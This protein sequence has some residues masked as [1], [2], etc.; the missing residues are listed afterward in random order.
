MLPRVLVHT[1]VSADGRTKGFDVD[2]GQFYGVAADWGADCMLTG[3]DTI[4]LAPEYVP[5][6]PS[7]PAP[8]V[9]PSNAHLLAVIDAR[10]RVRNWRTLKGYTQFWRD[11]LAIVSRETP[12]EYVD[13]VRRAGCDALVAGDERVDLRAAL[14]LLAAEHGVTRVRVD[15]GGALA[16]AL[17]AA[18]LVNEISLM[19][20]PLLAGGA[21]EHTFNRLVAPDGTP[22]IAA[23]PALSFV[24]VERLDGGV[25]RL[26]Y[27]VAAP[28]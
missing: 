24:G 14:E 2:M 11:P 18:G 17:L 3:A 9:A 20:Y 13:E 5:D 26:R 8:D 7:A 12:A 23:S 6:D 4:V 15:T 19:V 25:A 21:E 22:G 1:A 10:G 16:G 28:V 27:E